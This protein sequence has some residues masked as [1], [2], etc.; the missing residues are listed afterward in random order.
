MT[1]ITQPQTARNAIRDILANRSQVD[2]FSNQV[3]SGLKVSVPE[4]STTAGTISQVR[5]TLQR[6]EG[7]NNRIASVKSS[8][9]FQDDVLSQAAELLIRAKEI[10]TQGANT[11]NDATARASIAEEVFQIRDNMVNLANSTFQGKYIFGGADD[12]DAPFD[13]MTYT[14]P[15][16]GEASRR[17]VFDAEVGTDLTR[18]VNLTD[19]VSVTVNTPGDT[20]F[21]NSIETLERLGRALAGYDTTPDPNAGSPDGGGA[22]YSLPAQNATQVGAINSAIDAL[23]NARQDDVERERVS[24]GGKL[25]RLETAES[26]IELTKVNSQDVL[27]HLQNADTVEA[28]SALTQAQTVLQ[29]SYA[30]TS[31]LLNLSILDYI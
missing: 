9:T 14:N 6:F 23:D 8:L 7:Y 26:L 11:S 12:D 3:T 28:A 4:D 21:K 15:A 25:R 16:S 1:R 24:L 29:A 31:R 13:E 10:A 30:V 19:D 5:D 2:H 27:D 18:T 20:I 17:F 22:A